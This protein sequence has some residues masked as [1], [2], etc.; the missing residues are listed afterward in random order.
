MKLPDTNE[1]VIATHKWCT[2]S[3]GAPLT[4]KCQYICYTDSPTIGF[5]DNKLDEIWQS[6]E[7]V[8]WE[9]L[10]TGEP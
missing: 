5:F 10:A 3:D 8:S 6:N 1:W 4:M 9:P 2:R 7:V